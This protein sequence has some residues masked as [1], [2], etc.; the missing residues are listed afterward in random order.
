MH[1]YLRASWVCFCSREACYQRCVT[2]G[3]VALLIGGG[4]VAGVVNTLAGGAS[5][6]SVPLLVLIG[7]P[8]TLANG[9]NRV[10]VLV[11]NAVASW[12]FRAA[13][14]SGIRRALPL[15]APVVVGSLV[16]AYL[17]SLVPDKLFEQL[18]GVVM[19]LLVVPMLWRR[20]P[21]AEPVSPSR[22]R[23]FAVFSAIG[24]FGGAF[25]AGVGLFFVLAMARAGY[26]L[27][28][29]NS[30]KVVLN[31][32]LTA[33]ALGVFAARGQVLWLPGLV[34]SLGFAIGAVIGVRLAIAGG[35][36]LLRPALAGAVLLLAGRMI[37][38]Y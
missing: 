8:G 26:D 36:R 17:I 30:V 33:C 31:T 20:S 21:R 1:R 35:E 2:F 27:L 29:A 5:V 12:R 32:V 9:T 3:E 18:F 34:M 23:S 38:L 19:V 11:H 15:L 7:V 28:R 24:L 4:V 16:G 14:V 37:G 22:R 10:G 13:G 25:Q 6:L